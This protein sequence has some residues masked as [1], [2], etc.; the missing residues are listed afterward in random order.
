MATNPVPIHISG[1]SNVVITCNSNAA[2]FQRV[3]LTW[4]VLRSQFKV[5][6]SGSGEDKNMTTNEGETI[7]K[8][9]TKQGITI[10]ALFEYSP[11]G[12]RGPFSQAVVQN[13]NYVPIDNPTIISVTSEDSNDQDN[14]D[15]YLIISV[16]GF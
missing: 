1:D 2:Y 12:S 11:T 10:N 4:T 7:Y 15:S 9:T 5:I 13:P 3:T 14:N 16:T 8:F 6:F